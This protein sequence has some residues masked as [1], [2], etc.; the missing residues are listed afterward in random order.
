M[1][2]MPEFQERSPEVI[3][4]FIRKYPLGMVTAAGEAGVVATHVPLV[5]EAEGE[6]IRLRGHV[7]RKTSHWQAFKTAP[8]VLV[9]FTGPDA[10]YSQAGMPTYGLAGPGTTWPFMCAADLPSCQSRTWSKS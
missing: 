6:Q 9:A 2:P 10:R 8:E 4:N 7:M 3:H 1:Y 5:V